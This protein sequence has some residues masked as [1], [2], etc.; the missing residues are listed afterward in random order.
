[1]IV[2][3]HRNAGIIFAIDDFGSGYA[4]LNLLADFQPDI[5]KLDMHLIRHINSKGPRQA[6]VCGII[7]TC[8]DLGIDIIAE[9]VE[10]RNEYEWLRNAGIKYFQGILFAKPGFEKL[11]REFNLP[12]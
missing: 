11:T 7:K 6:I 1:M 9:G 3:E 10:T 8:T 4:G 5:I 2:N 12:G